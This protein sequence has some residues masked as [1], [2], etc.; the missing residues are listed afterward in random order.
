[1]TRRARIPISFHPEVHGK[2]NRTETEFLVHVDLDARRI[3]SIELGGVT[4]TAPVF[5]AIV[6]AAGWQWA[7]FREDLLDDAYDRLIRSEIANMKNIGG[8]AAGSIS[9]AQF[10]QHFVNKKP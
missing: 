5:R 1:M 10:I 8:R 9:A 6:E 7:D 2:S 4:L 3:D